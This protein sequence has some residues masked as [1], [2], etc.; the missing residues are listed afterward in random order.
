MMV[1]LILT[2]MK[3]T[4]ARRNLVKLRLNGTKR[5]VLNRLTWRCLLN[6]DKQEHGREA[7]VEINAWGHQCVNGI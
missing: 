1:M 5:S 2:E 7:G 3:H 4:G 6:D